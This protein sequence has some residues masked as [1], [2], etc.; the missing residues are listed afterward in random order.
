MDI[1]W[2]EMLVPGG[3][4][5]EIFLRGTIIYLALFVTMRFLPRRT[6]GSLSAS[7]LLIVVLLADA[8]Q[9]GMSDDYK[10]VTEGLILAGTIIGWALAIDWLDFKF[11]HWHI[12]N[13]RELLVID[14]GRLV[15]ENL[16]GQKMTEDELMSQ[17]RLHGQDSPE[18]VAKAYLEGD[19]H[20]SVILK[21]REAV[22]PP[23]KHKT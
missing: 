3:S 17:L 20:V 14:D 6:I 18:R 16:R 7:D 12:A 8:V 21:S 1:D 22:E 11:P 9:N 19:G 5:V 13:G 23:L 2:R 15:R 4:V 10:S